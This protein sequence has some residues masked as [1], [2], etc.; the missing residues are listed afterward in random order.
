[1][2]V[3]AERIPEA[4]MVLEIEI[5]AEQTK[6]SLDQAARRLAQRYR[7]PGFRKGKAPRQVIESTLG[8]DLVFEEAFE[9]LIP[10]AYDDAIEQEGIEPIGAPDLEI[11]E[12]D[13]VRFKATVPLQPVVDL[14]DYMTISVEKETS[15]VS[16]DQVA[17]TLLELQ[18]Q[19]AVLEPAERPIEYDDHVRIDVR[20]EAEGEQVLSEE[21]IEFALREDMV[22][23]VPGLAE[24]LLGLTKGPEHEVSVDVPEDHNDPDVA[25]KTVTFLV[26][27]HDIKSEDL[28][29]LDDDLASEV[30]DFKTI[31][32]LR[33]RVRSD[34][35]EAQDQR[36]TNE[37]HEGV[38]NAVIQK[39]SVEFAPSMVDH[40][41][42]HMM[43][44]MA[45]QSGQEPEAYMQ[46]L[47]PA[48]NQIR[49]SM[50][51]RAADRVLRSIVLSE[52]TSVEEV[53]VKEAEIDAEIERM[54]GDG[55]QA[56]QLRSVFG[57][58]QSRQMI[59]GN[60]TTKMTLDAL[61]EHAIKNFDA[62]E[63]L[64]L[65]SADDESTEDPS[66]DEAADDMS[67]EDDAKDA[68]D[69]AEASASEE[70]EADS[71]DD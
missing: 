3:T 5:D 69:Q 51:E 18:R 66:D 13:P 28:P 70:S 61:G 67:A 4:Q 36:I 39:A 35:V 20:A 33:S 53:E 27:V 54:I 62:G 29:E 16:D 10:K 15:E 57:N 30:G 12:K 59:R 50:R 8:E 37:F 63:P 7:I 49:E 26:T 40:E 22:I 45:Q 58:D 38:I 19:H 24:Q 17:D 68:E 31:E 6:K 56:E 9:R 48:A 71:S 42:N 64:T 55:P 2:K 52:A 25:G 43:A 47:G 65:V 32:E 60:L 23:A 11:V 14:G 46:A 34:L 41:L 1:M 44:E 21:G